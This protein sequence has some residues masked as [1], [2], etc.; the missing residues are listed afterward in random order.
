VTRV[1]LIESREQ[2]TPEQ[3]E[4][5]DH[6]GST[7]GGQVGRPFAVL[8]QRPEIARAMADLGSVI[9]FQSTLSDRDRELA[10]VTTAIERE[11][12]FEWQAHRP[13]ASEA[14]V[15]EETLEA[16]AASSDVPD[17]RD[18]RIVAY[19]R[20]LARTGKIDHDTYEGALALFAEA[21]VVEL[22]AIVGYYTLLAMVMNSVEA[23]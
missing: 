22:T 11:C 14:G 9:R 12:A 1:Q 13:L 18:A 6:I 17:D 7:R 19:V 3:Q 10:I 20:S 15:P 16:V 4:V 21:G 8:L 5:Y 23:C 2:A